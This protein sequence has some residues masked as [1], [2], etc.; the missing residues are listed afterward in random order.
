MAT[1]KSGNLKSV[2]PSCDGSYETGK[3][4]WFDS[5]KGYG[6]IAPTNGGKDVYVHVTE[7]QQCGITTSL[8]NG[9]RISFRS[10][11][12]RDGRLTATD[13]KLLP[14][15]STAELRVVN[16]KPDGW[17]H[18]EILWFNSEKRIGFIQP[19]DGSEKVFLHISS[20]AQGLQYAHGGI[21]SLPV[22]YKVKPAKKPGQFQAVSV[23]FT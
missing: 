13:V 5:V 19:K 10:F 18:G 2:V 11:K 6:F 9:Q 14:V 12:K 3:V 8:K 23:E 7:L 21:D 20:F 16:P 4:K 17:H 15:K 1:E 22:R